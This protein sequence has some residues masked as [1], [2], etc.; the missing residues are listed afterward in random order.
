MACAQAG[1]VD[2]LD[3][4]SVSLRTY[5]GPAPSHRPGAVA[6]GFVWLLAAAVIALQIAFPLVADSDRAR[7]AVVTVVVFFSASVAHALVYR[8]VM[9]TLGLVAIT[10]GGGLLAEVV[11]TRSGF[12]FGDYAYGTALGWQLWGVPVVVPLAWTMM[13]YPTYVA[14]TTLT[15]KRWLAALLGGLSMMAWDFFLDPMMVELR[16]WTWAGDAP[17]IP[18]IDGIPAVNFAGWFAVGAVLMAVMLLLPDRKAPIGQ[19]AVLYLWVFASSTVGA[20][21]FFERPTVALIG[22][23]T[24]GLVAVPFAVTAW[25][26][27]Q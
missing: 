9:W 7:L 13:L 2:H 20:A 17:S 4:P 1:Q 14:V 22:G 10:A 15:K 19:P 5:T 8:G 27:R 23:V 24:M 25:A 6:T 16:A 11:G 3:S 21:A 12:P 26:N 18:G